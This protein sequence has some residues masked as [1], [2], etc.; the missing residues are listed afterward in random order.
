MKVLDVGPEDFLAEVELPVKSEDF[1]SRA[2]EEGF[3][4]DGGGGEDA[5]EGAGG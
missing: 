3:G 5:V 4:A 2:R 1:G